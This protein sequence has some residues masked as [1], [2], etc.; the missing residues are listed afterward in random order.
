[1]EFLRKIWN[2]KRKK[3]IKRKNGYLKSKKTMKRTIN[4]L[5]NESKY[6]K[7]YCSDIMFKGA[8]SPWENNQEIKKRNEVAIGK[9]L[10]LFLCNKK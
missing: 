5:G 4:I 3:T 9:A 1:M 7:E 8:A 2:V 10:R 6:L